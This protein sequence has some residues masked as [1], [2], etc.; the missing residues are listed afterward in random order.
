MLDSIFQKIKLLVKNSN[1]SAGAVIEI[2]GEHMGLLKLCN[3]VP[4]YS[5]CLD[6]QLVP[7]V[8]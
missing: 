4:Q 2:F 7:K 1:L 8:N 6:S 3:K 5:K